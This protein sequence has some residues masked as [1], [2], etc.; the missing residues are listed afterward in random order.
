MNS[1]V[2]LSVL[3]TLLRFQGAIMLIPL[4]VAVYYNESTM[5]FVFGIVLTE[6]CGMF[7]WL[8]YKSDDEWKHREAFATVAFGWLTVTVFGTIPFIISGI[9]PINALFESMA[10]F[11]A[12]GATILD[13]IGSHSKS[14]LFWRSMIQWIGGMGIIV[15]FIAILPKLSIAGRQLFR[16]EVPGLKEEKIKPRIRETAKILW[17]VYLL[18]SS[19][20]TAML[21]LAG[22]SIYDAIVHT[23]T[24][25]GSAG[26]SPYGESIVAFN[27]PLIEAIITLFMFIAGVNFVLL[28]RTVY[29]DHT[30]IFRDEE[31][32]FYTAIILTATAV[33]I[34]TLRYGIAADPFTCLRYAL[35]QVV[36]IITTTGFASVDFNLWPDSSRIVLVFMMFIGGCA[37]STSGGPTVARVLLLLKYANSELFRFIH[38]RAVKPIKCN[39]KVVP[40]DL[41]H[42]VISFMVI[43]FLIFVTST[44]LISLM[45]VDI[46]TAFTASIATLGNVGPGLNLVG[47]MSSYNCMPPLAKLIMIANMWIGRL[48]VFT[49]MV[50]FTP[51][52]WKK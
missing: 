43:Y 41:I 15:L 44:F 23:F 29:I 14:I 31:F 36:S 48:E 8:R 45:N 46:I 40:K 3:G 34:L 7:I 39:G 12:T 33:L 4:L 19:L 20:Q 16:A 10:G 52:F 30:S 42:Q 26:F 17:M 18:I 25:I 11:T 21:Y 50:L 49:V 27:S 24:T 13:D 28:Y 38:P 32:K 5:P 37:G 1:A 22:M 6:M 35:F 2:V 47:P 9:S 51:E